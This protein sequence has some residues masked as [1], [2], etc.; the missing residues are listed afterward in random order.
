MTSLQELYDNEDAPAF[1]RAA[2]SELIGH[3]KMDVGMWFPVLASAVMLSLKERTGIEDHTGREVHYLWDAVNAQNLR[4][5][6]LEA[7][8]DST[9]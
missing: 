6:T 2:A 1:I 8:H 9:R 5:H 3:D 4:I 7:A